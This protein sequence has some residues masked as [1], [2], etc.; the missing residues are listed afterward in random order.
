MEKEVL[1]TKVCSYLRNQEYKSC[2]EKHGFDVC[3]I[4]RLPFGNEYLVVGCNTKEEITTNYVRPFIT[5]TE[6][7]KNEVAPFPSLSSV[8][9]LIAYS[10]KKPEPEVLA[11]IKRSKVSIKFKKFR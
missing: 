10:G 11:L 6:N 8:K 9:G 3:G 7:F 1:K 2:E 4:K 5:K